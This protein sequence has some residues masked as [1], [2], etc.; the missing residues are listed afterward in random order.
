MQ[1]DDTRQGPKPAH[2]FAED[3]KA[4]VYRAIETRRDVRNEFL[5]DPLP[6]EL[7]KKLLAAAHCAPS[8]GFMQP[9]NFTLVSDTETR[10]A[11]WQAF[12]RANEEAVSMFPDEK[13]ALYR[14]LKLEGIRKAPLSICVTCDPTRGGDVVL[15]RTHNLRMDVYSTVCAVQNVWLAARAEGVG[16]GWVS[17]FHDDDIRNILCIPKHIEIVAWLC[18]GYVSELYTEPEL[19]VKGWRQRLPLDDLIFKDRWGER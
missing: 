4:A 2:E 1:P 14:S 3:E 16:V 11:V 10:N 17:I 12:A 9:W 15:G 13:Q 8:V 7:I 19:A 18:V 6:D 5:P